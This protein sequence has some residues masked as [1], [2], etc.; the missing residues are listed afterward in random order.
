VLAIVTVVVVQVLARSQPD[1]QSQF[2]TLPGET[3]PQSMVVAATTQERYEASKEFTA[4]TA[5]NI[6]YQSENS[7]ERDGRYNLCHSRFGPFGLV[8][9][10]GRQS[11]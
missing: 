9:S 2:Y 8:D 1:V 10:V 4:K 7:P 6:Q 3:R 11:A 5:R